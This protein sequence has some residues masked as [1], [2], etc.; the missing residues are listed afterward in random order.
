MLSLQTLHT[1]APNDAQTKMLLA[2]LLHGDLEV[3]INPE[4]VPSSVEAN[5]S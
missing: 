3:L 4:R 5:V 1:S 2:L